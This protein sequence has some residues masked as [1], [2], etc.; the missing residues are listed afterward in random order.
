MVVFCVFGAYG[1]PSARYE[2]TST[3]N[4]LHLGLEWQSMKGLYGYYNNARFRDALL[5]GTFF[6]QDPLAEKYYPYTPYHYGAGNPVKFTDETGKFIETVWDAISLTTG[7]VSLYNNIVS[8]NYGDAVADGV[9]VIVDAAAVLIPGVPGGAGAAIKAA[10]TAEN[11]TDATSAAKQI[12]QTVDKTKS[13]IYSNNGAI[14][15]TISPENKIDRSLLNPPIKKGTSPTFKSDGE[16]VEIHHIG[17]NNNG[18]F[19]E[20]HPSEHRGKGV[21]KTNHPNKGPTNINRNEFKKAKKEYW[22]NEYPEVK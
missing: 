12:T 6:Q 19:K 17:Q 14:K 5:A 13:P 11:V 10:R 4:H 21:Y 16:S 9:G 3:N 2:G 20:M 1:V 18:P 22:K 7:V 15:I 8:G